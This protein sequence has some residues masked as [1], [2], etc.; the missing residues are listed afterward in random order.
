MERFGLSPR[1]LQEWEQQGRAPT[2]RR[3]LLQ[4]IERDPE[5]VER[6]LAA[7]P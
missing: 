4:V 6:A 2:G 7:A 1:T 3:V 5:A